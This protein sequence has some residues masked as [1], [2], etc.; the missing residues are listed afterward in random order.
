MTRIAW[1]L[2]RGLPAYLWSGWGAAASLLL[3]A[4]LWEWGAGFYGPLILPDPLTTF[5]T[6]AALVRSGAAWPE[7]AATARRALAGLLLAAT[8]GSA[9]GLLAGLSMTAAMMARP[10]VTLLLGM[11]PIAWLVLAMLWFGA[12]DGTPVFTVFVACLPVVFMG[13]LQGTRTLD[14]PLKDMARAYRLPWRM[15]LL[16]VYLP[17]VAAYLFPAW[18]TALGSSWKVAVMAELLATSDGVGAA[19]AVARSHLDTSA[20]LAWISAVVGSLLALEYALLEPVKRELE[21]WRGAG[22]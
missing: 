1:R 14:H 7:L 5:A 9:L 13:A 11:P 15:R 6:L 17:H 4:A 8:V 22:T 19:L 3:F 16:D 2:L 18:I 10:W 12:G 20:S 21:R